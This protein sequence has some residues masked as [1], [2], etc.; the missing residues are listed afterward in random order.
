VPI[1]CR[2]KLDHGPLFCATDC[3]ANVPCGVF[4]YVR[5]E[6]ATRL[7]PPDEHAVDVAVLDMNYGWPNLGHDS[8]VHAVLDTGCDLKALLEQTGLYL[9]V[10]SFDVR[11]KR[12]IPELPGGRFSVYLGT[13]GP[14]HLDPRLNHGDLPGS[15]GL[16]ED[17]SWEAPLFALFD[18]IAAD[19]EAALLSVCHTFGVMCRW[20]GVAEPR[21]RGP[22]KDG[23]SVGVRENVLTAAGRA[24]PWFQ[25]FASELPDGRR[26]RILDNRL[27]DLVPP[28]EGLLRDAHGR[29]AVGYE[30][31]RWP[32]GNALTMMEWARDPGGVMPRIFGVNHH[33]EIVDRGR[34]LLILEQKRRSD[35]HLPASWYEER[36]E[37]L[38]RTFADEDTERR[39]HV[40][41]DYT[42]LGPLRFHVQRQVRRRAEALG[43]TVDLHEDRLHDEDAVG[44]GAH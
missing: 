41:S 24:H 12:L 13:G 29:L 26:L 28:D 39:L 2:F 25:R 1:A 32:E 23:K 18:A 30:W 3:P 21:L 33:P 4:R 42:L 14:G 20:S 7:P 10:L 19:H 37:T 9:R 34:Q 8:L 43:F 15:Q 6:D 36:I 31:P 5:V 38:T 35:D 22:E 17:P 27:F 40:T 44:A 11:A 16:E